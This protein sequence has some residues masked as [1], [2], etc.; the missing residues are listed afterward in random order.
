[1]DFQMP[2]FSLQFNW[3]DLA[4]LVVVGYFIL[5]NKGF[6][7]TLFEA[8]GFLGSLVLSYKMY[9]FVSFFL[10]EKLALSKGIANS[11]GFFLSWIV[12]ESLLFLVIGVVMSRYFENATRTAVNKF[13]GYIAGLFQGFVIFLFLVSAIFAFPVR[14]TVKQDILTSAV[15][16]YFVNTSQTLELGLREVFKDTVLETINFLTIRPQSDEKLDLGLRVESARLHVDTESEQTML[17]L[18]NRERRERGLNEL[19]TD[20]VLSEVARAYARDMFEHGFFSHTSALDGTSPGDRAVRGGAEFFVLGE[21]L[22]FAPDVYIA[23]QGL[24][25]SEGHRK[26]ILSPEFGRV[27][28]GVIDGGIY[29]RMFVQE[30]AD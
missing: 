23:H 21:N 15:G 16:P 30:F 5:T 25:N 19:G 12:I 10:A 3:V 24:M 20:T 28:I 1:M 2:F 11:L 26:N 29:G 9:P 6:I 7:E 27:G 18:I 4:F 14:G 8:F 13:L 17:A 22:A